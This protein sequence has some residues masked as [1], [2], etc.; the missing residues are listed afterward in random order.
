MPRS[1]VAFLRQE[2]YMARK[3][4]KRKPVH[5]VGAGG[6]ALLGSDSL[7]KLIRNEIAS[8]L[9]ARK[10][11]KKKGKS[12]GKSKGKK[13]K[14]DKGRYAFGTTFSCPKC[15][16]KIEGGFKTVVKH[17][18][19]DH[20]M[21]PGKAAKAASKALY[22]KGLSGDANRRVWACPI[23]LNS[24]SGGVRS[25]VIHLMSDH[26]KSVDAAMKAA[27]KAMTASADNVKKEN[28]TLGWSEWTPKNP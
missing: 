21:D 11:S 5:R 24:G 25:L 17:L 10:P 13:G 3:R 14:S 23:C 2:V 15:H 19:T 9:K 1:N 7:A 27:Q 12:K 28:V 6:R 8:A 4:K 20:Y 22:I 18:I 16:D 26:D